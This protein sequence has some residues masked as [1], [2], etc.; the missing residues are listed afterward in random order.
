MLTVNTIEFNGAKAVLNS[1]S[2]AYLEAF[3]TKRI[4]EQRAEFAARFPNANVQTEQMTSADTVALV[5]KGKEE[6][7]DYHSYCWKVGLLS[8]GYYRNQG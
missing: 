2:P 8:E 5:F 3:G 1:Y 4:E 6:T 7:G